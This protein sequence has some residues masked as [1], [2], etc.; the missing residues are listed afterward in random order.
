VIHHIVADYWSLA[1]LIRELGLLLT[2][3]EAPAMLPPPS[4]GYTDYV[5]WQTQMLAGPEGERLWSYW[6]KQLGGQDRGAALPT[7]ELPTTYP[8]PPVQSHRGAAHSFAIDSALTEELKLLARA[9]GTTLY[10]I[11]LAAFQL[12]LYRY[13][14]Q[15]D[16]VVGTPT[17]GR[18]RATWQRVVGY[19][20]NSVVLRTRFTGAP[21]AREFIRQVRSIVL[22]ALDHQ[23]YPFPLLVERLQPDRDLSRS[24]LFQVMFAL[25]QSP[26]SHQQHIPLFTLGSSTRRYHVGGLELEGVP[27]Q[28]QTA[29]FDLACVMEEHETALAG[30]LQYSADLFDADLIHRMAEH[31]RNLLAALVACPTAPIDTLPLL[32]AQEW[33]RQVREWNATDMDF[34][35][36]ACIHTLIE[37]Q[38]R[39]TPNIDAVIFES[40]RL[41]YHDL[42]LRA[43]QLAHYLQSLGVGPEARIGVCLERSV[44]LVIGLL[45]ILKAG[46][47]YVPL[48]P[49]YPQVGWP[50]CL[51]MSGQRW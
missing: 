39:K 2:K 15:Q 43:N 38:A 26:Q 28:Q 50:S 48:D 27:F 17:A 41:T 7:L 3:S 18:S 37:D 20:V 23:G 8:R 34:D 45:A 49:S 24:P 36:T 11:L 31:Y 29:Q 25:E 46:G 16:I 33:T 1:L 13:T 32:G 51:K 44:D 4:A 35:R 40:E 47:A 5:Q 21:S 30:V 12:L 22:D 14:G 19:F 42:N 10:T 9:E 6:Q